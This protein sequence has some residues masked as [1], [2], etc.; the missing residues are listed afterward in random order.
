MDNQT[1][2]L[3]TPTAKSG[4]L[5]GAVIGLVSGG[6][7][8]GV[9][10]LTSGVL[11]AGASPVLAVGAT[12]IDATPEWL[13]SF[14]IRTFGTDDKRALLIGIGA[15]LVVAAV[16]LGI[17]SL[18][19]PQAGVWGLVVLG[20]VGAI[21]AISRPANGWIAAVPALL[22]TIAGLATYRWIRGR[23]GLAPSAATSADAPPAPGGFDRRRFLFGSAIVAGLAVTTGAVGEYLVRRT[24]ASTSRASVRLPSATDSGTP[25]LPG[26]DLGVAGVGPFITPNG[27]FYRVDTALFVPAL[28]AEG[29]TLSIGGMVNRPMTITFDELLARPL[30]ERDVTLTC[31]SNEIGGDYLGNARWTGVR[32][33]SL[34]AEAGIRPGVT[35]LVSRS[36][37]G[38]T[39]G[40][41]AS[42]ALD[43][44]DA[45]LAVAMNGEPLPL[46]HGFP[47]RMVIPGLY[48]YE[49]ACKWIAEIEATTFESYSAYWVV[50]GWAE[51]ALIETGSRIDTPRRGADLAAGTVPVAGIAWAQHRG[52]SAVEVQIDRGDWAPARLGAQASADTWRQW[53][54][55]WPAAPGNH[56]IA[57]RAA[58]GEGAVQTTAVTPPFPDGATGLHEISVDVT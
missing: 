15:V 12:A 38:F 51:Q 32:L 49:S 53:V 16:A 58:D 35:Q 7:A 37:D 18:R 9:A 39:T 24:D 23:A 42:I 50:R 31:I 22:G 5:T 33:Q 54:Y 25:T 4:W 17:A 46:E 8:V 40:T 48:G 6:I 43:G 36:T 1:D 34:L 41:P 26:S 13:K 20:S 3:S 2:R 14:A 19:H 11:G 57:V 27:D 55:D 29:W 47:V 44:R 30:I 52:I 21:A 45:M 28:T 56:T 10:H